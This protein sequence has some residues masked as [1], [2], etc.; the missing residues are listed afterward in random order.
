MKPF[1]LEKALAGEPFCNHRGEKCYLLKDLSGIYLDEKQP[2]VGFSEKDNGEITVFQCTLNYFLECKM[3]EEPRPTVTLTLPCPLKEPQD[4]MWF[5]S[6]CFRFQ[7]KK[8]SYGSKSE[9]LRED[10]RCF[11]E[12]RYFASEADAQAWLDAMRNS[13][14]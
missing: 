13:R 9:M 2:F 10:K 6:N 14:R 1:D 7:V 4:E 3:W 11:Q 5:I 12:G 8:S